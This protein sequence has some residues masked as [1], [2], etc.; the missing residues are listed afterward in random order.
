MIQLLQTYQKIGIR[1]AV[2]DEAGFAGA[3]N[4]AVCAVS[5]HALFNITLDLYFGKRAVKSVPV[6]SLMAGYSF[7][8]YT[9]VLPDLSCLST[10]SWYKS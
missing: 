9:P 4:P 5:G 2:I 3:S 10:A 7:P 1:R 6:G 8:M